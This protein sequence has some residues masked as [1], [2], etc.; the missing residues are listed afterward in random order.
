MGNCKRLCSS[1]D[2]YLCCYDCKPEK[3]CYGKCEAVQLGI[4]YKD[5]EDRSSGVR[6]K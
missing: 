1:R 4:K 5:C 2:S 6:T 3:L